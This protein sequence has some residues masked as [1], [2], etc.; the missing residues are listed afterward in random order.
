MRTQGRR[1][2]GIEDAGMQGHGDA[3]I[4]QGHREAEAEDTGMQGCR[5]T[6]M[7]SSSTQGYRDTR[8]KDAGMHTRIKDTEI[9]D[10]G[11]GAGGL[12]PTW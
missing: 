11:M 9:T 1:D 6:G 12:A 3:E 4:D 2:A 5:D 10:R 7:Q 8:V